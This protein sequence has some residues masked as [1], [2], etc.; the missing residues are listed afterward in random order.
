LPALKHVPYIRIGTYPTPVQPLDLSGPAPS[1]RGRAWVKRE[2]LSAPILGGNKVRKLRFLFAEA[3]ERSC[4]CFVTTGGIGSHHALV[5][6]F[7]AAEVDLE[8]YIVMFPHHVTPSSRRT[9]T[10]IAALGPR[11]TYSPSATASPAV[12]TAV[13][14]RLA[15]AGRRPY[16]IPPGGCS[17]TGTIGFVEAGLELGEQVAR[18]EMDEPDVVVCAYGSGGTAAGL[19]AGLQLAGLRTHVAA[20][21][22][23][24]LPATTRAWVR[25]LASRTLR[26]LATLSGERLPRLDRSRLRVLG[27]YL[28][29]RYAVPTEASSAARDV[30]ASLGVP[31]DPTYT[32]KAFAAF[33]DAA[34]SPAYR[35]KRLLFLAT[36]DE[37]MP[38]ELL[39]GVTPDALPRPLRR[40]L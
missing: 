37:R 33:L 22:T 11:I 29:K 17:V 14:A 10:A 25:A 38:D 5:S 8:P 1:F 31:L 21:R 20:V 28:G 7:Y 12:A 30:G 34:A 32:A 36:Y 24:D 2:D 6:A 39:E 15:A 27:G 23:Y 9:L 18:G 26:R 35:D 16:F 4:T 13:R 19:C 40:Y 3:A